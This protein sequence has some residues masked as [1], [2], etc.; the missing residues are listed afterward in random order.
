MAGAHK[1]DEAL[2]DVAVRMEAEYPDLAEG[3]VRRM[4][5]SAVDDLRGRPIRE[6]VPLLVERRIRTRL[7]GHRT[8][9]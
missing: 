1:E 8:R 2:E 9:R 3:V 6:F 7:Q 5:A 4:I